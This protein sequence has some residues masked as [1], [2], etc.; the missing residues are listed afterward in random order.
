[1]SAYLSRLVPIVSPAFMAE[2]GWDES[3]IGYLTAANIVGAL[4]VL[5]TCM[6]L[7]K[8]Y[9]GVQALQV[10]LLL[11]SASLLLFHVPSLSLALLA[12][13]LI[14]FSNGTAN[15]AGSEVLQRF[16]PPAR[17]NFVFSIKQAGVP[18]GGVV[19]GLSHSAAGRGAGLAHR[20][21]GGGGLRRGRHA[22]DV[23]VP[24][25]HRRAARAHGP[26]LQ[27]LSFA[28]LAG[29]LRSLSRGP[30]LH[31]HGLGRRRARGGAGVLVHLRGDLCGG[32][33]RPIA[34][35]GGPG[36]RRD[37]G[38]QRDR[39]RHDRMDRR[40]HRLQHV[41]A[42]DRS[43]VVRA[44]HHRARPHAADWPVWALL[45]LAAFAGASVSGWNGVQIAEVARRSPPEMVGETA[46]GC[47]DPGVRQQHGRADRVRGVRRGDR[48]FDLA[49]IAAGA[50]SL[51]CLP[52]LWGID[53]KA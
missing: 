32:R 42:R 47:G 35:R 33:A 18:L 45:L 17:R 13:A 53:R 51:L 3:W 22:C 25:A 50:F 11:G 14:G 7:I 21:G 34:E 44:R 2:F 9:G 40:P 15:P 8:R 24:L 30:G 16:T 26:G 23:A 31:A 48:R 38:H 46:A 4:F 6:G 12:S 5:F 52:L 43:G 37:A 10:C 49:F 39:P 41:D 20:A 1:M 36:V 29:P 27:T 19:A 28:D